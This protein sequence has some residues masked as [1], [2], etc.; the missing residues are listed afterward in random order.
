MSNKVLIIG[1]VNIDINVHTEKPY[2]LKDSNVIDRTLNIGGVGANIAQNLAHLGLDVSFLT[3]L[4]RDL[5]TSPITSVLSNLAI[6]YHQSDFVQM[7]S[8]LYISVLDEQG[9][10]WVG[11]NDMKSVELLSVDALIRKDSYISQFDTIVI[12]NNLPQDSIVYLCETYQDKFLVMDAV[13]CEKAAKLIPVLGYVNLIKLNQLEYN[14]LFQN[15][16]AMG[17]ILFVM[18]EQGLQVLLTNHDQE[19]TLFQ[20]HNT[21]HTKPLVC[22]NIVSTSGAGDALLSGYVYGL[23]RNMDY[24]QAIDIG[25][26]LAYQTLL[27]P[28]STTNEVNID[29]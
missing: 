29:E 8:N 16:K 6:D 19:I 12:D 22:P 11:L 4:G 14:T 10:L 9:D 5:F 2:T 24:K 18:I 27:V 15:N 7:S 20:K 17:K 3:V 25:K 23:I 13:S 1:A 26:Q 21:Y 28:T